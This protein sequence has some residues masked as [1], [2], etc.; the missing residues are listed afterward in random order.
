MP[1]HDTAEPVVTAIL[2]AAAPDAGRIAHNRIYAVARRVRAGSF[3]VNGIYFGVDSRF[4]GY[5]QSG[6]AELEG[7]LEGETF[8]TPAGGGRG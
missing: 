1:A 7:L 2:E 3:S 5:K 4:G 6:V 8:A